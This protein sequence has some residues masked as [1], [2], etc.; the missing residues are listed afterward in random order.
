MAREKICGIYVIEAMSGNPD[1]IGFKYVG[2]SL[3]CNRRL[4]R[5]QNE[6]KLQKH[7]N[8]KLQRYYNKYGVYS[9]KF[10]IIKSYLQ[11]ELDFWERWWI[12]CFNSQEEGFNLTSGGHSGEAARKPITLHNIYTGEIKSFKSQTEFGEQYHAS[13]A[14]LTA[15]L[16]GKQKTIKGWCLP[17]NISLYKPQQYSLY[18]SM[19]GKVIVCD[20]KEFRQK[21]NIGYPE[22]LTE[23]L[24]GKRYS[25]EGW[26]LENGRERD[27]ANAHKRFHFKLINNSGEIIEGFN[28]TECAKKIGV[29]HQLL[30]NVLHGKNISC[31]GWRLVNGR[32]KSNGNA[33]KRFKF[34]IINATGK[35]VE[36]F[37]QTECAN[38]INIPVR[39]L[40]KILVG[41][42]KTCHGW[43]LL[44][45]EY[46]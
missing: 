31:A 29:T 3:N 34:K 20:L 18:H 7:Y 46:K 21:Y 40:N 13:S 28:Q 19:H 6:L 45:R 26:K 35:I 25:C 23:L 8:P 17:Q 41:Q 14:N 2:Q 1:K 22:H 37:N 11:K 9:F 38:K 36:G 12:K 24:S 33:N 5:H 39:Q 10:Y 42:R 15:L 16:K 44:E 4:L 32:E 30:W 43:K 27:N